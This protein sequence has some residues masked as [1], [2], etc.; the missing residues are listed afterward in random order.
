MSTDTSTSKWRT[1]AEVPG[2]TG[3]RFL[4]LGIEASLVNIGSTGLLVESMTPL[5]V[6]SSVRVRF[7]GGF[8]PELVAGRV[9]RCEVCTMGKGTPM[10]Y[11]IGVAF[12]APISIDDPPPPP[13][14]VAEQP[15]G[16]PPLDTKT[17]EAPPRARN[18]W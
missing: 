5:T 6:G 8:S 12:D 14:S 11:Q 4:P 15:V 10:R 3:L 18:R 16:D 9:A 17:R 1:A 2:I 7:E 13:D